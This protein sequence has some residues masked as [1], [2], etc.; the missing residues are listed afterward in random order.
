MKIIDN[1]IDRCLNSIEQYLKGRDVINVI[2]RIFD[3][4]L[5]ATIA[6]YLLEKYY[7]KYYWID[8]SDYKGALNFIF[9]GKFIIPASL[10]IVVHISIKVFS[11]IILS[12]LTNLIEN[13]SN[14]LS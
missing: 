10:F 7:Y 3:P 1:I 13:L 4:I 12:L 5:T 9:K 2:Q 8:I 11:R 6:S 14:I